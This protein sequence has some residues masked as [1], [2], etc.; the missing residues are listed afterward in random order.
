MLFPMLNVLYF[1]ISTFRNKFEPKFYVV[2]TV[3]FDIT[4]Q[5]NQQ[6]HFIS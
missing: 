6:K 1:S 2:F 5:L 3:H 4:Q